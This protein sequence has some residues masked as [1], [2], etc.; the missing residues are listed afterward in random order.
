[1][2]L[3]GIRRVQALGIEAIDH[4][5]QGGVRSLGDK[6]ACDERRPAQQRCQ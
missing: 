5:L 6:S 4:L 3:L 2:V 1:M